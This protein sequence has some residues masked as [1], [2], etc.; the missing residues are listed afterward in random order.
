MTVG[1]AGSIWCSLEERVDRRRGRTLGSMCVALVLASLL[2]CVFVQAALAQKQ[3][4]Q[5]SSRPLRSEESTPCA[6]PKKRRDASCALIAAPTA[7]QGLEGSG[8]RGGFDPQ[9]LRSAYDLPESGGSGRTI[10]IVDAY[11][12]PN[13][14]ADLAVYREH[15]GLSPC[16]VANGCFEK[17]NQKGET[18]NYPE[19]E[20][21]G[22]AVEESLDMDM[23]S[24]A[25][26]ECHI[27][28]VEANNEEEPELNAAE[29]T[30]V[31]LGA[32]AVSNS[33]DYEEE[34][35]EETAS[36]HV[37]DH[38]GV[39]IL[40]AGG[41][42]T[43]RPNYP[44]TS[45]YVIAV[46][47]T[48]LKKEPA[49]PRKWEEQVWFREREF[50]FS[51]WVGSGS[52]C[53]KYEPKPAWQ[54]DMA[55][56]MRLSNDVS[57]V[58]D[59]ETP[60]SVYDTYHEGGWLLIG[61]TSAS[62][63]FLAGVEG[64]SSAHS[65]SLGAEAFYRDPGALFDVS[66]GSNGACS[67]PL[68]RED[69]YWCTA[70]AGYDGPTGNGTPDGPL[71]VPAEAWTAPAVWTGWSKGVTEGEVSLHGGVNPHGSATTYRFEYGTTTSYGASAPASGASAGSGTSAEE[72][73]QTI[74]GLSPGTTYHYR[75]VASNGSGTTYGA[76]HTFA[77]FLWVDSVPPITL[78]DKSSLNGVACVST[79]HCMIVG[80]N[81]NDS[82]YFES[83]QLELAHQ[84]TGEE[85]LNT[86]FTDPEESEEFPLFGVSCTETPDICVAAGKYLTSKGS[87]TAY[88]QYNEDKEYGGSKT[89][90][91]ELSPIAI[92]SGAQSSAANAV[93]CITG[94]GG[95]KTQCVV[96]G[97]YVD[98][99]GVTRGLVSKST[100]NGKTWSE[101]TVASP[102]GAKKTVLTGVSCWEP[103]HC[104]I[105]GWYENGSGS[106]LPVTYKEKSS[107]WEQ[108]KAET[109]AGAKGT[110]LTG[111]SCPHG[112]LGW[113]TASGWYVNSEGNK[114]TLVER[115]EGGKWERQ[116]TPSPSGASSSELRGVSCASISRCIAVGS[117]KTS[118]GAVEALAESWNGSWKIQLTPNPTGATSDALN[119][120]VSCTAAS[121]CVAAG[122]YQNSA[123]ETA[124]LTEMY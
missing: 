46:G 123:G 66:K 56:R 50:T 95:A 64:L 4:V 10:A 2:G 15:Y 5:Y 83:G 53:S 24:A 59:P 62:S 76:D 8:E 85:W 96:A 105:V 37:F 116:T 98:G 99:E 14:E 84:W 55:C 72:A 89:T 30:A 102:S 61:G 113:C 111:V 109:P 67:S 79:T 106:V 120:G 107:N 122:S 35:P 104:M 22:W 71:N 48:T 11:D 28:L 21:A 17:V 110:V 74:T 9:D 73:S 75:L 91:W 69:E 57:A 7:E 81:H 88:A 54:T 40:F 26:Q 49:S 43:Y 34:W 100:N 29:E 90:G 87:W 38:P 18:A 33:W 60:L 101:M 118:S 121:F 3:G 77:T 51:P 36:D 68:E 65:I 41:D 44:A 80:E 117:Y 13:A 63:P 25:C 119:G 70:L 12:D 32:T 39:P 58:A 103:T 45:P 42:Y 112:E 78:S 31:A 20:E 97:E 92:P 94:S 1:Q 52:Y 114:V 108:V 124:A 82:V 19:A 6:P 93:G 115:F 47:G 27:L 86:V 16:T 23:V